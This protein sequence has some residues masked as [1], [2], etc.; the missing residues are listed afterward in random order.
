[1]SDVRGATL[2]SSAVW[3][4]MGKECGQ[5]VNLCGWDWDQCLDLPAVLWHYC[6]CDMMGVQLAGNCYI[7]PK[8]L[9][10][11][12][13][14]DGFRI[15]WNPTLFPKSV[16]CLKSDHDRF[17]II[18]S[19]QLYN[20]FWLSERSVV[21]FHYYLE[22]SHNVVNYSLLVCLFVTV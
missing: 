1:M 11:N 19:V 5:L 7:P 18:A 10:Q 8:I 2:L 12:Y 17:N 22:N 6:Q 3:W 4:W 15:R 13:W 14:C 16:G 9:M 20:N 21:V